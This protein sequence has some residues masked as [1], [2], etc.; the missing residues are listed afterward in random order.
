MPA[1]TYL[2]NGMIN[3]IYRGQSFTA[4]TS[5]WVA[6]HT[7]NPTAAGLLATELSGGSYVRLEATFNAPSSGAS[8]NVDELLFDLLPSAA[9]VGYVSVWDSLSAGNMLS[10]DD[11]TA[12]ATNSGDAIRIPAGSLTIQFPTSI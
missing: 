10:Y 4:P 11:F 3:Y 2:A 1:S 12:I 5:Y 8:T 9:S 6:L 7:A